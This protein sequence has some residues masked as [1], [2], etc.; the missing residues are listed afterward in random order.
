[1]L[2]IV[3]P[4]CCGIDVHKTFVVACIAST[5]SN[6]ETSY[7]TRR[8]STFTKGLTELSAWLASHECL[9]VCMESTGKYW[10]P[11]H[12]V[13]EQTVSVVL[14]H[15]KY[16]KAIRG[17]KTDV[18]DAQWIADLF[19]HDLVRPSFIPSLE[20]RQLRDLCRYRI[21]LVNTRSSEKNRLQNVLS[22]SNI[23]LASVVSDITGK[24]ALR[25]IN[26]F[27]DS[28]ETLEAQLPN[29]IHGKLTPKIPDIIDAMDGYLLPQ[30]KSKLRIILLQLDNL[31]RNIA[32]LEDEIIRLASPFAKWTDLLLTVP[33][34]KSIITA[35]TV[36]A[37]ISNDM[38]HFP[39]SK[40]LCSWAGL[41]PQ[42]NESA[43]KKKS[44]RI[45]KAGAFL[46]P[47]LV[48]CSLAIVASSKYP[49]FKNHYLQLKKRRGHKKALIAVARKVITAIYHMFTRQE[50]YK[51]FVETKPA[52]PLHKTISIEDAINFA[53]LN[54]FKV[55]TD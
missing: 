27:L 36:L 41:T 16:V 31:N 15:P 13:L 22:T 20:I 1:M 12:N 53:E 19:K 52:L 2:K 14:A 48:Q 24:S 17:K 7:S 6:N 43:G 29:L 39:S 4:I 33:G 3:Y 49:E 55:A 30:Q 8:F 5:N 11:V 9:N 35:I 25:I 21:K 51:P 45:S 47:L 23:Q 32:L 50:E 34:V 10:I 26:A 18:K 46:K 54:G 44:V 28:P 38:S 42:N 37:E 40:H